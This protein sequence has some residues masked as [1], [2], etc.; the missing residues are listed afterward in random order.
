[1][2][3][4]PLRSRVHAVTAEERQ[5]YDAVMERDRGCVAPVLD[6]S[7]DECSGPLTRQ[8][9]K[10]GPGGK[11]ITALNQVLILC[12]HHHLDGWAT[13]KPALAMQRRYLG[14]VVD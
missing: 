1:M 11:R 5:V 9:V 6:P 2:R 13:S 10:D 3:R 7:I 4:T 14:L 8:H 12:A